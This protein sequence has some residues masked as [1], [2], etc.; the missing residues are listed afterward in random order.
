MNYQERLVKKYY[1]THY[2]RFMPKTLEG[3]EWA[4]G[5]I[6]LNFGE[7][8]DL[9]P[10]DSPILDIACGV[11]YLEYYLLKKGFIKIDAVDLSEEQIQ[12]AK[13][14]LRE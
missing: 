3:L 2:N 14:I 13:N 4:I 12:I 7:F 1:S 11:G 8:F 10:R 9:I 6:E 5:R